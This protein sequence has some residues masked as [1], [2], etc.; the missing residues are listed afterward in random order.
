MGDPRRTRR[1]YAQPDHPWQKE[2]I[3]EEKKLM[4][5]YGFRNK[6][7]IWKVGEFLRNAT[8]QAKKLVTFFNHSHP[9]KSWKM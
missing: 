4:K 2:R 8:A 7:E 9:G 6:T 3:D 5:E 1:K